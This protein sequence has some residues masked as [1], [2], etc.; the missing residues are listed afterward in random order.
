MKKEFLGRFQICYDNLYT[1]LQQL[2]YNSLL[3]ILLQ[4]HLYH[5]WAR[6][7]QTKSRDAQISPSDRLVREQYGHNARKACESDFRGSRSRGKARGRVCRIYGSE[8]A[9][10]HNIAL[11]CG[12]EEQHRLLCSTPHS[13]QSVLGGSY[14]AFGSGVELDMRAPVTEATKS[15]DVYLPVEGIKE[16]RYRLL[17][18]VD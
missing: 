10:D 5:H 18:E 2:Y 8:N 11:R 1:Y 4:Q 3:F 13:N 9:G 15:I 12:H 17:Y 14:G 6:A 16:K 7:S